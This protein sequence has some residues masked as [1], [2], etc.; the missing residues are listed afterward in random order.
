M[1][2]RKSYDDTSFPRSAWERIR[3]QSRTAGKCINNGC[4][5]ATNRNGYSSEMRG[6]GG[7][8]GMGYHAERGNQW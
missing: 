4:R 6:A 5:V 7:E 2:V 3:K 8:V 1:F